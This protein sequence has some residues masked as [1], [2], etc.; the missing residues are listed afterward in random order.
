MADQRVSSRDGML[1]SRLRLEEEG[2]RLM[3]S[4]GLSLWAL[5]RA[6]LATVQSQ[7]EECVPTRSGSGAKLKESESCDSEAGGGIQYGCYMEMRAVDD[8]ARRREEVRR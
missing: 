6:C 7:S 5:A 1:V 4:N 3:W 8:T 2:G